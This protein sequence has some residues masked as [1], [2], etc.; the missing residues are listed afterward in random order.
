MNINN[1]VFKVPARC[2]IKSV[3]NALRAAGSPL[4]IGDDPTGGAYACMKAGIRGGW[5]IVISERLDDGYW[6]KRAD[7]FVT[8]RDAALYI[9]NGMQDPCDY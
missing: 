5:G 1:N 8:A 3:N 7:D 6:I 9:D 4:R 2:T